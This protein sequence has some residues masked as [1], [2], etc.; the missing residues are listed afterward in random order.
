MENVI[1]EKNGGPFFGPPSGRVL[2]REVD[3]LDFH[4]QIGIG[5]PGPAG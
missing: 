2:K 5:E 3:L 4:F 1:E